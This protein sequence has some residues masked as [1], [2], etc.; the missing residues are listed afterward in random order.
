MYK[1]IS[2]IVLHGKAL[3][4]YAYDSLLVSIGQNNV[5]IKMC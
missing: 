2:G 3:F 5:D 4:F 1:M